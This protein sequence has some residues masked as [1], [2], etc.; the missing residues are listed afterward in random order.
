MSAS[1]PLQVSCVLGLKMESNHMRLYDFCLLQENLNLILREE[2]V[3]LKREVIDAKEKCAQFR[4]QIKSL[5][6][7]ARVCRL[8]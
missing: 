5:K 4:L 3:I 2:N 6:E 1:D 7:K 8:Q